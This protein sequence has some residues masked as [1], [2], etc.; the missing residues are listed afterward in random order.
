M[1]EVRIC[2]VHYFTI[3]V[4]IKILRIIKPEIQVK[5]K[6]SQGRKINICRGS[7]VW[8]F[9]CFIKAKFV[10]ESINLVLH[11]IYTL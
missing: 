6:I 9:I 11:I 10:I 8:L 1:R 5:R 3:E 2:R 4:L 7:E